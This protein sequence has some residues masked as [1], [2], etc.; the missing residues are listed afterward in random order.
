MFRERS[1]VLKNVMSEINKQ[2]LK[3]NEKMMIRRPHNNNYFRQS[4]LTLLQHFVLNPRLELE[5][6]AQGIRNSALI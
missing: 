3:L 4:R 2:T 6:S 5:A 1:R